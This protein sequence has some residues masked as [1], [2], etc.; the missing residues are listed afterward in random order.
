MRRVQLAL[1]DHLVLGATGR[2][3]PTLAPRRRRRACSARR[4]S[5]TGRTL[6]TFVN[7]RRRDVH[8]PGAD[9]PT[10]RRRL[11]R[12]G[13]R[14]RPGHATERAGRDLPAAG[15]V[16]CSGSPD[17]VARRRAWTGS[18]RTLA[19]DSASIAGAT[20]DFAEREPRASTRARRTACPPAGAV[21]A[22]A[23]QAHVLTVPL[24]AGRPGMYDARR[25]VDEWKPLPPRL[26][27]IETRER[28]S[29]TLDR[30][31]RRRREVTN[32]EF[33]AFVAA[34][35]YRPRVAEPLPRALGRRTP[36]ARHR[37]TSR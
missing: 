22:H 13:L 8:R 11:V 23:W 30:R 36:G 24:P 7:R 33:A 26:H 14:A 6:W 12:P 15:S 35:G 17:G 25:I 5:S 21:S 4:S 3:W 9:A 31:G 34:T 2:R 27:G 18:A 28:W 19:G 20:A 1:G 10:R 16:A 32:A 37:G 29:A